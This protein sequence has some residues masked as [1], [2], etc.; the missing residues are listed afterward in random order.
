MGW[1]S[2][3]YNICTIVRVYIMYNMCLLF[4]RVREWL[5]DSVPVLYY[6]V[7]YSVHCSNTKYVHLCS[8]L[9]SMLHVCKY[10]SEAPRVDFILLST[11]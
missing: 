8:V 3:T 11:T 2:T 9:C 5:T 1:F 7:V 10:I 4:S 6:T